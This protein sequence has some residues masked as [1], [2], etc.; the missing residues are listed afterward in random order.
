MRRLHRGKPV[1]Y[2]P[3]QLT[4]GN[5]VGE[6]SCFIAPVGVAREQMQ[7]PPFFVTQ[8][9]I[10]ST[11]RRASFT[12]L[13]GGAPRINFASIMNPTAAMRLP[14][15]ASTNIRHAF[16]SDQ[17]NDKTALAHS[18]S[19]DGYPG[20]DTQGPE[21]M[22]AVGGRGLGHDAHL[23]SQRGRGPRV[24]EIAAVKSGGQTAFAF[25]WARLSRSLLAAGREAHGV[26]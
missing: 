16:S 19:R 11:T 20:P 24:A 15:K 8:L 17:R 10:G 7:G 26:V 5:A 2:Q 9:A 14:T 12:R 6:Q 23:P 25:R 18:S 4:D 3:S 13:F 1:Y 22:R 21:P